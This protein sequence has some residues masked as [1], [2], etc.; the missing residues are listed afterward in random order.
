MRVYHR[1]ENGCQLKDIDDVEGECG[2][3]HRKDIERHCKII[4]IHLQYIEGAYDRPP[5]TKDIERN[6]K[7]L[8]DTSSIY[9]RRVWQSSE[10]GC[11]TIILPQPLTRAV[12]G[13]TGQGSLSYHD[14]DGGDEDDDDND[15]DNGDYEAS[16]IM[17]KDRVKTVKTWTP[18]FTFPP[19]YILS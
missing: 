2:C 13:W 4:K 18:Q 7:I 11:Q 12:T 8:K 16:G 19:F 17:M 10:A 15:D 14:D 5:N 6:C 9:W 1:S 3:F